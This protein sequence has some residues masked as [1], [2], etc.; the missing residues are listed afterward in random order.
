MFT[1]LGS[2]IG[3]LSSM[4]PP[5]IRAIERRTNRKH[6]LEKLKI[7]ADAKLDTRKLEFT[8]RQSFAKD[9]EHA[10]LIE[11]DKYLHTNKGFIAK[12]SQSI[13]PVITYVFFAMFLILNGVL[14][15]NGIVTGLSGIDIL[16]LVWSAETSALFASVLSFWFGSRGVEKYEHKFI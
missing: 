5:F 12:L 13:R 11:H 1:V 15:W 2:L 4:A 6:E 16:L 10:R 8:M 9:E 3:F 7:L 14:V